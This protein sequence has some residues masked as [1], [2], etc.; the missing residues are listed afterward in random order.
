MSGQFG[1][2]TATG[3]GAVSIDGGTVHA[4]TEVDVRLTTPGHDVPFLSS[5][6]PRR[7]TRV[8]L[9][10]LMVYGEP[11]PFDTVP[12]PYMGWWKW[13]DFEREAN[14]DY[15]SGFIIHADTLVWSV[16]DSEI[17]FCV[18]WTT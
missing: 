6:D 4:I 13:M 2:Y 1:P 12:V 7:V 8:G 9:Y 17:E 18:Y 11:I 15:A 5:T 14:F 10:G 3:D 16:N